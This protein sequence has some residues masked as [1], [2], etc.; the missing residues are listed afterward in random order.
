[1]KDSKIEN[2]RKR[3]LISTI[4][5]ILIAFVELINTII[6]FWAYFTTDG[7]FPEHITN[8]VCHIVICVML[9]IVSLIFVEVRKKD[10]PF[11]ESIIFK[12]RILGIV[13]M[14][15][16]YLPNIVTAIVLIA[17]GVMTA[18]ESLTD[19]LSAKNFFV[20]VLGMTI[21]ILSAVFVYGYE[22]QDDMDLIA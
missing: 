17:N 2:L 10:K 18:T 7:T 5:S 22:L 19:L 12:L 15:G 8:G 13:A 1:M 11:S 16:A 4:C 14:I 9:V 3:T 6:E 21:V 20:C